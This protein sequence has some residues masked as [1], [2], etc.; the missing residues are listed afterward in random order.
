MSAQQRAR[1]S[2]VSLLSLAFACSG[3][4]AG[5]RPE[6]PVGA[7]GSD[8]VTP[9]AAGG[10]RSS[11]RGGSPSSSGEGGAAGSPVSGAGG[12]VVETCVSGA[13]PA[14]VQTVLADRC[15]LCHG[16]PPVAKVPGSLLS[17][18]DFLRPAKSEPG[19]TTAE[20]TLERISTTMTTLRMPPPPASP[21][22]AAEAAT[23]SAWIQAGMPLEAC[24]AGSDGGAPDSAPPPP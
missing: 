17:A 2:L 20:V 5:G 19:K 21:L 10:A 14:G 15:V 22:P 7:G 13:L 24:A 1:L 16:N 23:L 12:A 11:A 4:V 3:M 18:Q 9:E 8:G 6:D